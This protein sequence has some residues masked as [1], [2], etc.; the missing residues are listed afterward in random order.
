MAAANSPIV[1][2]ALLAALGAAGMYWFDP[3]QGRR[4]RALV[5]DKIV[6]GLTDSR[7]ASGALG[8]DARHRL[9]GVVARTHALIRAEDVSDEV[10]GER[11]RSA[12]GRATSHADAI[13]VSCSQGVVTV[14]GAVLKHEHPR[15]MRAVRSAA[16]V[17]E[18]HDELAAYGFIEADVR[19]R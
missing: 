15:V 8:R 16:S 17:S 5:R 10:L 9:Q 6:S 7:H 11:I 12:L 13:E 18:V 3:A 19:E 14:R 1:K 2:Y 4:R